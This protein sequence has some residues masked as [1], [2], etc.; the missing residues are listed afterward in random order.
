M[1]FWFSEIRPIFP[2]EFVAVAWVWDLMGHVR[3]LN[4]GWPYSAAWIPSDSVI[5]KCSLRSM[6]QISSQLLFFSGWQGVIFMWKF[7][8]S[9]VDVWTRSLLKI[10]L[11]ASLLLLLIMLYMWIQGCDPFFSQNWEMQWGKWKDEII[12]PIETTSRLGYYCK[13]T[14][15]NSTTSAFL[16]CKTTQCS[17]DSTWA[18]CVT[19]ER[20]RDKGTKGTNTNRL[21]FLGGRE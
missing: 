11:R 19:P 17:T 21:T 14:E 13:E 20:L 9:Q 6:K 16:S 3:G 15:I 10:L 5:N 4:A 12:S 1:T 8:K 2:A 7:S 18:L